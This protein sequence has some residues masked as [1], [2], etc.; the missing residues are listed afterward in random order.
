[1]SDKKSYINQRVVKKDAMALM[2][3]KPLFTDDLTTKDY[4]IVKALRSPHEMCIR[5]RLPADRSAIY[6][7]ILNIRFAF[8]TP[9]SIPSASALHPKLCHS[10]Q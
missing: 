9:V 6:S 5:D 2:A 8:Q 3:G 4:L 1:M 7:L 10:A